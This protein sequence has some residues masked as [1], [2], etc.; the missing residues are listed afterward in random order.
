MDF[1][2]VGLGNPGKKYEGTRHNAGFVALE[3]LAQ[4]LGI[5]VNRVK[6]KSFCGDGMIGDCRVLLMQPQTF[7]NASGEAVKEAMGF[8]KLKPEQVLVIL[9]D[10]SLPVGALRIRRKGSDG[11]QKGMQSIITLS[12]SDEFPRI[13]IGIGEKPH[14]DYD[15]S[16]WVLSRFT[17]QEA[18]L[19]LEVAQTAVMAACMIVQG[20]IDQAM[21]RYSK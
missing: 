3:L 10:I 11:G 1:L 13:K 18:P 2:V 20:D 17:K 9:D 12:G 6:F 14:P 16:A 8:Y 19:L 21:N 4:K 5:K 7:M 15:L